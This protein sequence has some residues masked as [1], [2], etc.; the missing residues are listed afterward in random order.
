MDT[1]DLL[2]IVIQKQENNKP[3]LVHPLWTTLSATELI[4]PL[5]V[6]V[7]QSQH[8]SY[9]RQIICYLLPFSDGYIIL[10]M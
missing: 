8:D 7:F 9:I 4:A 6:G 10:F 3:M 1:P 5:K 2:V